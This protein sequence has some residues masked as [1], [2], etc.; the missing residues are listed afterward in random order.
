MKKVKSITT[1]KKYQIEIGATRKIKGGTATDDLA[2]W[3]KNIEDGMID[4]R[5]T[6]G[7]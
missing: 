7:G 2:K 1:Y 3:R 6:I 4:R 5:S